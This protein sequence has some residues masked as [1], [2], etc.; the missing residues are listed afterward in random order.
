MKSQT[1]YF[2]P[3]LATLMLVVSLAVHAGDTASKA[4]ET[5]AIQRATTPAPQGENGVP[6]EWW[7]TRHAEKLDL[8]DPGVQLLLIGDSITHGWEISGKAVWEKHFADI[9]M[10]NLGFSAD[11]T[12]HV[13]WRFEHGELE[14]LSPK[15]A[16]VM[17]GT[18]NTGHLMD[19]PAA[20]EAGVAAIL[21][22]LDTRLP[23]TTVLLLAIFP[24]GE[25]A[26]DPMRLN[27][28]EANRLLEALAAERG[29][30]FADINP[31]FLADDGALPLD[32]M[33]DLLHPNEAGYEIWAQQLKPWFVRYLGQP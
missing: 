17:I 2:S 5:A 6:S 21:D 14:G 27:N 23:E 32:V 28:G 15:L 12:E 3:V 9:P 19:P 33:P 7:A 20:I 4:D 24:R 13:L 8:R 30:Q 29:V 16:V 25:E 1:R 11:R 31:A 10:L 22:E 26:N 18:N